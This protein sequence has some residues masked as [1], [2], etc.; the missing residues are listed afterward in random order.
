MTEPDP[1]RPSL[2]YNLEKEPL[3]TG[4]PSDAEVV[5]RARM[6]ATDREYGLRTNQTLFYVVI[7][8]V[9]LILVIWMLYA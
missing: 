6:R 4:R 8:A 7:L 3:T 5:E 9:A 2:K 1:E